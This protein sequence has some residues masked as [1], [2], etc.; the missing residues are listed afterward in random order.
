MTGSI[1]VTEAAALIHVDRRTLSNWCRA[2]KV[3]GA[4]Q[5]PGGHWR[6]SKWWASHDYTLIKDGE[7]TRG[8]HCLVMEESLGR[9]LEPGEIVHHKDGNKRNNTLDNLA[10]MTKAD[11]TSLHSKQ[12]TGPH[13]A[14]PEKRLISAAEAGR[15]LGKDRS[16]MT[17]WIAAGKVPAVRTPGGQWRVRTIDAEALRR[18]LAGE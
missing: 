9:K 3:P 13:A 5:T 11:H 10:L 4:F 14:H 2:G 12:R 7:R 6:V 18:K 15:R 1:T 17:R 16:T 8:E